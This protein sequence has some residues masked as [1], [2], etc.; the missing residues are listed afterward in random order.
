MRTNIREAKPE[1]AIIVS[2]FMKQFEAETAF[3]KVDPDHAG[4]L[5]EKM[6]RNGT[7]HMF[8]LETDE[9]E[10][11]GGLGCVVGPDLHYPRVIA[12]ETYWFVSPDYRGAGLM[13]LAFFEKWAKENNCDAVAM[14]H[15]LDS[16]PTKLKKLY[17]RRGYVLI[18][19]H[20]LKEV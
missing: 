11:V 19:N 4:K 8:I 2:K 15:L 12:V 5:Y 18:E 7:G 17:E 14:V 16:M 9:G 6:I 1:E 13:L 3:V 10:M 20:Y